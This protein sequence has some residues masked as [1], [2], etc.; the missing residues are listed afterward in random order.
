[1]KG[2]H[3]PYRIEWI[4]FHHGACQASI[5]ASKVLTTSILLTVIDLFPV[6]I[7]NIV[8]RVIL[9]TFFVKSWKKLCNLVPPTR[10]QLIPSCYIPRLYYNFGFSYYC[11]CHFD[12]WELQ[13]NQFFLLSIK[14]CFSNHSMVT[15]FNG[16]FTK[17]KFGVLLQTFTNLDHRRVLELQLLYYRA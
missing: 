9:I 12:V 1:M 10:Q 6:I 5:L 3:P 4:F 16:A 7:N 8:I 15:C 2:T 17:C 13:R 11:V 14:F